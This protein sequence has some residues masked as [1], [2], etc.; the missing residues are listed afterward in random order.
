MMMTMEKRARLTLKGKEVDTGSFAAM[1]TLRNEMK[2]HGFPEY[3]MHVG[4]AT[5]KGFFYCKNCQKQVLNPENYF[6]GEHEYWRCTCNQI[7]YIS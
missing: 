4:Y 7:N 6:Y 3:Q 2:R 1:N 5:A